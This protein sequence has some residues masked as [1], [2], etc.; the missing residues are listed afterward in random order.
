MIVTKEVSKAGYSANRDVIA[1]GSFEEL[2]SVP[3]I[4]PKHQVKSRQSQCKVLKAA[5]VSK[6]V[7]EGTMAA[8]ALI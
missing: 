7:R 6:Q 5:Y 4:I 1:K 3:Y 2:K 8:L